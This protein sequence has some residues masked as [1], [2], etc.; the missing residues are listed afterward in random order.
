MKFYVIDCERCLADPSSCSDCL[1]SMLSDP[2]YGQPVRFTTQ[3]REA[4]DIMAEVGLVPP[5]R[6]VG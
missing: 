6:L 5:L 3:E 1:M 2:D 4:L